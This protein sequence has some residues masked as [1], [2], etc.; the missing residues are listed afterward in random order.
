MVPRKA[1]RGAAAGR[2]REIRESETERAELGVKKLEPPRSFS[3]WSM[4]SEFFTPP[5]LA[6]PFPSAAVTRYAIFD[7]VTHSIENLCHKQFAH[8]CQSQ[9][10]L[11][12]YLLIFGEGAGEY[13]TLK[14]Q[15]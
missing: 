3:D 9:D 15:Q 12:K 13:V 7:Q 2:R 8:V 6:P 10:K 1:E 14:Y 11:E 5:L 4:R